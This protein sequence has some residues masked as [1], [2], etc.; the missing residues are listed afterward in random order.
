VGADTTENPLKG[1]T[2]APR[3]EGQEGDVYANRE[4][5]DP[6]GSRREAHPCAWALHPEAVG[7]PPTP[8]KHEPL[9]HAGLRGESVFSR[10]LETAERGKG[11]PS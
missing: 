7:A 3:D 2:L 1:A 9:L 11:A 4:L 10:P 6:P 5:G 8:L